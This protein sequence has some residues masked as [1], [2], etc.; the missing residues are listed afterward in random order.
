MEEITGK[1]SSFTIS[2]DEEGVVSHDDSL[3]EVGFANR[4][5]VLVGKLLIKKPYSKGAFH[6]V[7]GDLWEV[8]RGLNIKEIA[9][10]TFL[11]S[12]SLKVK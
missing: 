4:G 1:W 10:N 8:D 3:L 6:E 7:I 2:G 5:F 11:F 9:S 12:L